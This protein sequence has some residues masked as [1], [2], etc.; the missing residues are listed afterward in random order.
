MSAPSTENRLSIEYV[1]LIAM[2]ISI[3]AM[4]TDLMLPALDVIGL[5]LGVSDPN[6]VHFVVTAFFLGIAL[7]QLIAGPL[8]DSF[9]RRP[10]IYAGYAL[11]FIGCLLSIFAS[12]WTMMI[13]GR[14]LQGV[15][16]SGPRIVTMAIVRDEYQGRA[17]ARILSFVMAVFILVP[18]LAP[19]LGQGLIYIGGWQATFIG[20]AV[21]SLIVSVWFHFRQ[22]ETLPV[23]NRRK[24]SIKNIASGFREVAMNKVAMGYTVAAGLV[25]GMFLGYLGSAQQIFQD[26]FKVGEL[27]VFYFALSAAAMGVASLVNANLVMRFGMRRL[28]WLALTTLCV[29]SLSFF[30]LLFLYQGI[31][32]MPLF[33]IWQ[34]STFFCVAIIFGNINALALE[35]LGHLAGLGAAFVGA[36]SNFISLPLAWVI[37]S[38]FDGTVYPLVA[39][40]AILGVLNCGVVRWTDLSNKT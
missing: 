2:M 32:P 36:V 3:V 33:L 20:L 29:L 16:A 19:M 5:D 10:I 26:T 22:P 15:G 30:A 6:D 8:S 21:L 25:F 7:G 35:P 9:G 24:L 14:V 11:F 31:P 23:E 12:S 13:V 4:A 37:G 17:M 28:N 34:L 39:G 18:I 27:F 38:R 40:F 1:V